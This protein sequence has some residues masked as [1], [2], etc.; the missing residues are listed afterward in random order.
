V[1]G[2][3]H[4]RC[5][6]RPPGRRQPGKLTVL[7]LPA[8]RRCSRLGSRRPAP[9]AR[10]RRTARRTATRR[11]CRARAAAMSASPSMRRRRR[12]SPR[13]CARP[14]PPRPTL[15]SA[16]PPCH[17]ASPCLTC[18]PGTPLHEFVGGRGNGAHACS[19]TPSRGRGAGPSCCPAA[20]ART[21]PMD[22]LSAAGRLCTLGRVDDLSCRGSRAQQ[23]HPCT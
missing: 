14:G 19:A 5:W 1:S 11:M 6:P 10:P 23:Q 20:P 15:G 2:S 8:P 18:G 17:A 12:R 4:T 13:T 22:V 21:L 3:G 9:P 16:T 7:L